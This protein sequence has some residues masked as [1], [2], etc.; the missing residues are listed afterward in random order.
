MQRIA[1][2]GRPGTGKSTVIAKVVE[3]LDIK[4]GGIQCNELR[5]NGKRVGFLLKDL[6]TGKTGI[7]SHIEGSGPAVG[8]YHVHLK[9]LDEIGAK[10]IRNAITCDLVVIDEIGL[11]ELTSALFIAAVETILKSDRSVLVV[12]HHSS[13]HPL[14]Q[15]IRKEFTSVTVDKQNR[16]KMPDTII[17]LLR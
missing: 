7:L 1:I 17:N 8:K 5:T 6:A 2:T 13:S 10:A 11:M 14:A 4:V 9:D 16:D 15:R 12:V 3:K